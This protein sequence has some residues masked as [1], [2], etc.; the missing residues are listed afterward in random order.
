M[1]ENKNDI[2]CGG[3]EAYIPIYVLLSVYVS[4]RRTIQPFS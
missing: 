1:F 4:L 3:L 2:L